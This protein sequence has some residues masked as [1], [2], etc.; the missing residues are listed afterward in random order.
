MSE[1][2]E[3]QLKNK[4]GP[5]KLIEIEDGQKVYKAYLKKRISRNAFSKAISMMDND[6]IMACEVIYRDAVISEISDVE[7]L[8]ND[9]L[10]LSAMSTITDLIE[11]K[12]VTSRD[13]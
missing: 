7:I 3:E 13:L 2:T 1:L 8:E 10:F 4:Y 11:K 9:D 6:P 12:K 5:I